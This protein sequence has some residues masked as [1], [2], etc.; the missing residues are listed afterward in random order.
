[1]THRIIH[2][3]QQALLDPETYQA[4]LADGVGHWEALV[5]KVVGI[6][7]EKSHEFAALKSLF[8]RKR[9]S[10]DTLEMREPGNHSNW[11]R[12]RDGEEGITNGYTDL[13]VDGA[14]SPHQSDTTLRWLIDRLRS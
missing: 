1:M 14:P 8:K 6:E 9:Y 12:G 3:K 13:M 7:D 4:M 11:L 10:Y 2:F 5:G